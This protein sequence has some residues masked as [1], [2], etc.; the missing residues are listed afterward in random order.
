MPGN[1]DPRGY[2]SALG[3]EHSA[4]SGEIK[5]AFKAKAQQLHP[6]RNPAPDATRQFQFINEAYRVLGDAAA[7]SRYDAESYTSQEQDSPS[8]GG[9]IE[10]ITCS[11]CHKVSAQPRYAIYRHVISLLLV[12]QRSGVQGIF[13]SECG[14]KQAYKASLRTWLLGWWGIPWGPIYSLHAVFSNMF[15]GEQPPL[16][17]FR[18]LSWQAMYFASIGRI[19]LARAVALDALAFA[20]KIAQDGREQDPERAMKAL[21][22]HSDGGSPT[23][24]LKKLWGFG[25]RAFKVQSGMMAAV[26]VAITIAAATS[27]NRVPKTAYEH[28]PPTEDTAQ[29][30]AFNEPVRPLP[31]TGEIRRLWKRNAPTTLAPLRV[32]TA[33]GSLNYYVKIVDWGTH[34]PILVFFVRSGKTASVRVPLGGYEFRY[35]AGEK[36]Y[37]EKYL[38][39][40]R[41]HIQK[42][43]RKP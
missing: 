33:P 11:I 10:P 12:T 31:G 41:Y 38:F 5:K 24:A 30:P 23:P 32:V 7:R 14:A 26:I 39:G 20:K 19:D 35:A 28:V 27:G 34:A 22:A 9:S 4:T 29:A 36:W 13:C 17:N 8:A 43:R 18:V 3:V 40:T 21:I 37:G 1:R 16:N 2:Y 42:S 6:D 25:S 15:G